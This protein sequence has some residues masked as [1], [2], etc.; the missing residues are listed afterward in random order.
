MDA[1]RFDTLIRSLQERPSRRGMLLGM[2]SGLLASLPITLGREEALAKK[3]HK[4]KKKKKGGSAPV[5]APPPAAPPST[6]TCT[7][8]VRNGTETDIDCG[9]PTCPRCA[10]GKKCQGAGDCVGGT[11]LNQVCQ[12]TCSDGVKNGQETDVD[13]GGPDCPPCAN[14][15]ACEVLAD[16]LSARCG[17]EDGE[18]N[19]CE[20]CAGDGVCREFDNNGGCICDDER[21]ICS[22]NIRDFIIV[23]YQFFHDTCGEC[24]AGCGCVQFLAGFACYPPCGSPE[25]KTACEVP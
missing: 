9:G 17:D 14:G 13:C 21:G 20:S 10:A 18:G 5:A 15:D 11:C 6:A 3:K 19:T 8:G 2:A 24:P 12:P 23:G 7:D 22:S 4:R 1:R 16:C 25:L